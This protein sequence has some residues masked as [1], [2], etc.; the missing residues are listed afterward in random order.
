MSRRTGV[1][2]ATIAVATMAAAGCSADDRPSTNPSPPTLPAVNPAAPSSSATPGGGSNVKRGADT[3][4]PDVDVLITVAYR[5]GQV[6]PPAGVVDVQVGAKVKISVT[7]DQKQDI[8]VQGQPDRSAD[9][10]PDEAEGVDWTV[11][12]AGDTQVSL[13]QAKVVLT[14]VH[15]S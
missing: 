2:A 8:D 11:T 4:K 10:G 15:A 5:N 1:L 3:G 13:R 12:K 7:S 9:V 14:T 6:T